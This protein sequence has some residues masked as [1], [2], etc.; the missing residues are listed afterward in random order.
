MSETTTMKTTPQVISITIPFLCYILCLN[1]Y[2][3]FGQ[4]Y[5]FLK[6]DPEVKDSLIRYE[7]E[8]VGNGYGLNSSEKM[9]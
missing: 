5:P 7:V 3:L 6:L 1:S 2:G 4:D 8:D 9:R